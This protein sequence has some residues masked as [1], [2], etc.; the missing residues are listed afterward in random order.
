MI[1]GPTQEDGEK[2]DVLLRRIGDSLRE[3]LVLS[4]VWCIDA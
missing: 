3:D 4:V 1:S 2:A